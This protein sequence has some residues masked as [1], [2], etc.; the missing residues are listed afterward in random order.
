MDYA[1]LE[2]RILK[3]D[4]IG[5]PVAI[6]FNGEQAFPRGVL[7][8]DLPIPSAEAASGE[9]DNDEMRQRVLDQRTASLRRHLGSS[10]GTT[11]IG[12]LSDLQL[13]QWKHLS[14]A[15]ETE[16]HQQLASL[17]LPLY[18]T[19]NFD[20]FLTLALQAKLG[21]NSVRREPVVWRIPKEERQ[22]LKSPPSADKPVVLHLDEEP[23]ALLVI[24]SHGLGF[25][26]TVMPGNC[27]PECAVVPGLA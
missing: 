27:P 10:N 24:A 7:S 8:P 3:K 23:P 11:K 19:T 16:I 12:S 17:G 13:D 1:G 26:Y 14:Q 4:P 15:F 9:M 6:T 21:E 5:Y 22:I 2:V 20:N 18:L 25:L